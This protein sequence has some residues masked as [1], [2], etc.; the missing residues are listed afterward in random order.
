MTNTFFQHKADA[1]ALCEEGNYK[2]VERC[3]L[4]GILPMDHSS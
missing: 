1:A 3:N 2:G 4:L